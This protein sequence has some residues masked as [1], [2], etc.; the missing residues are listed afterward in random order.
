MNDIAKRKIKNIMKDSI[1]GLTVRNVY[2]KLVLG[3]HQ[4]ATLGEVRWYMNKN[5]KYKTYD[6]NLKIFKKVKK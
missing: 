5:Y 4:Y 1:D 3:G 2:G 6:H